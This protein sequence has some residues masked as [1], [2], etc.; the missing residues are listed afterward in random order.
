M[1]IQVKNVTKIMKNTVIL[2][3]INLTLYGKKI[4]GLQGPNG[5]GKTMLMRLISGLIRPTSGQVIVNGE[6]LGKDIDFPSSIGL[7]IE[8]PVFLPYYTGQKN[9][10]LLAEI[11]NKITT[12]EV[13]KTIE[14]VGLDPQDKRSFRKYSLGMKQRLGIAAAIM[15]KPEILV[16]DEPFNALDES[17]VEKIKMIIKAQRERGALV[18]LACHDSRILESISD[19]VYTIYEGRIRYKDL[20]KSHG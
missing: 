15:E 6:V 9:L 8:N 18:V 10:E 7:L 13:Q 3:Q 16:L 11:K 14:Q 1:E 19:E 2:D 5:S 17:G 4:Y 12:E 20:E